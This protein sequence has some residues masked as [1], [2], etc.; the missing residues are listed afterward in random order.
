MGGGGG[1]MWIWHVWG[2]REIHTG[3]WY[4]YVKESA[5]LEELDMDDRIILK[6][7]LTV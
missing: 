6:R 1:D 7:I 2:R 4:K 3:L 5:C